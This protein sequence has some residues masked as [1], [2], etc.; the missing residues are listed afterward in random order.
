MPSLLALSAS[1]FTLNLA[2]AVEIGNIQSKPSP[3]RLKLSSPVGSHRATT[4][5]DGD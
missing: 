4:R 5:A 1:Q 2:D 3:D